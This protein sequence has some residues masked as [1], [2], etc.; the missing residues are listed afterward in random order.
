M[1]F[2]G[3][4]IPNL[5]KIAKFP[6]F[7]LSEIGVFL[8]PDKVLTLKSIYLTTLGLGVQFQDFKEIRFFDR[9]K[10]DNMIFAIFREPLL[11]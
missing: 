8:L 9:Q 3:L 7:I 11:S 5:G 1:A 4:T 6:N 2:L 10:S